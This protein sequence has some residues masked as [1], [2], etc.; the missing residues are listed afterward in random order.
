ME[1]KLLIVDD[2][3]NIYQALR[4]ALHR[5]KEWTTL[6]ADCGEAALK[7]LETE[8]VDIVISDENMPGMNGTQ[9]LGLVRQKWPDVIRMMLTGD[10]RIDVVMNAVN[11]GEIYRFFTKPCNE[12]ELIISI[13]DAVQMRRLK[14]E[15]RRLLD[16]VK[17]QAARIRLLEGAESGASG[18]TR[19]TEADKRAAMQLAMDTPGETNTASTGGTP[20]PASVGDPKPMNLANLGSSGG[21]DYGEAKKGEGVID[22]GGDDETNDVDGLLEEIRA[23][24]D[25]LTG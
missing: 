17:R 6:Y 1:H 4:R 24:L 8:S 12:A 20:E 3:P 13:R 2:E 18:E 19:D 5:E 16:T 10:A 15:S 21:A 9:L 23:Q 11:R 22:L 7:L 14:E 25:D